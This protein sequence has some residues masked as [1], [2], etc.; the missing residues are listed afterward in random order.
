V[1]PGTAR[2]PVEPIDGRT[3]GR[4]APPDAWAPNAPTPVADVW[5]SV[6]PIDPDI[7]RIA[8]MHVDPYAVGDIWLV[9]GSELSVAADTG[10]GVVP[11]GPIVE[12]LSDEPVLA[13]ALTCSYDHAGGWHSFS[14]RA[15]HRFD[16]Q[17]LRCPEEADEIHDYLTHDT[18]TA[19]PYSGFRL[20]DYA[21]PGAEP[22]RLLEDGEVIDL[23]D[24]EL[25]VLHTPGRSPGGLS[26][27]EAA[28][29][30]LFSGEILY[31]GSHGPA[32][33]PDDPAAYSESLRR[34]RE[35]PVATVH[36]GHYGSFDAGRMKSLTDEQ[37][38]DL[39]HA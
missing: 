24:R 10:S 19:I 37:L 8:E 27:W 21:M 4:S 32:W 15:C 20:A 6:E 9:M 29:A 33:P 39:A 2:S 22:T 31:D 14:E 26:L 25:V 12:A 23:G 38:E 16:A 1:A 11:A 5:Y 7:L 13:V 30:T 18:M 17:E 3:G 28:T 36:A 34:L 35:L